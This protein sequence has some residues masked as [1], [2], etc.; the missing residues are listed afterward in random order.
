MPAFTTGSSSGS[1]VLIVAS[2]R[3]LVRSSPRNCM[4]IGDLAGGAGSGAWWGGAGGA[5][6][7]GQRARATSKRGGR[8]R[9]GNRRALLKKKRKAEHRGGGEPRASFSARPP[10][11]ATISVTG[12][13]G[14]PYNRSVPTI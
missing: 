10:A 6:G 4:T 1:A 2:S 13:R 9:G 12:G 7:G 8:G 5:G 11:D 14:S 3:W